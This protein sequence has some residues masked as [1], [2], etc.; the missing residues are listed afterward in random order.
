[1]TRLIQVLMLKYVEASL[2]QVS[3]HMSSSSAEA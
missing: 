3:F 2:G 1:M